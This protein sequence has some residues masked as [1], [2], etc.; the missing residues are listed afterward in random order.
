M[1]TAVNVTGLR[2]RG[3]FIVVEGLDRAGKST[4]VDLLAERLEQTMGKDRV[5][6]RKF[7]GEFVGRHAECGH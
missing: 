5:R 3:T 2:R 6:I 7:P 1:L 4:Q